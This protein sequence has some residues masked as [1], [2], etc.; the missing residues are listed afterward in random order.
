MSHELLYTS[1]E[2]GLKPGSYGFCTVMATEGLSKAL[3]DRLESLSGYEHPFAVTDKRSAQNPVNYSHLIVTVANQRLHLLSRIADA[4]AD[5]SGRSNKLAH[6][7][8]LEPAELTPAGPATTLATVDFCKTSFDGTPRELPEGVRPPAESRPASECVAWNAVC[9]DAGWAGVLAEQTLQNPSRPITL[10]FPPGCDVL[11]LVVEAMSLLPADQRWRTTF[12]TYFTKLPAGVDCQWRF[13][14]DGTPTADQARRNLQSPPIDLSSPGALTSSGPLVE[15]ARTGVMP[16]AGVNRPTA[17]SGGPTVSPKVTTASRLPVASTS[18]AARPIASLSAPP[19]PGSAD[20]PFAKEGMSPSTLWLLIGGGIVAVLGLGIGIGA[21]MM[22]SAPPPLP[23]VAKPDEHQEPEVEK[24]NFDIVKNSSK[25]TTDTKPVQA[26][27]VATNSTTKPDAQTT[28]TPDKLKF[29]FKQSIEDIAA[30]GNVLSLPKREQ[31]LQP[32]VGEQELCK[33]FLNDLDDLKL[34]LITTEALEDGQPKQFLVADANTPQEVRTWTVFSRAK[35]STLQVLEE[36]AIGKFTLRDQTLIFEWLQAPNWTS[37][38]GL[39]YCKLLAQVGSEQVECSL[40]RATTKP[41]E[42]LDLSR[43]KLSV[44][45]EIY[46]DSLSSMRYVRYDLEL[47]LDDWSE[48]KTGVRASDNVVQQFTL[49]AI[50]GT[51]DTRVQLELQ[52][53]PPGKTDAAFAY[54]S[55]V[56]PT[57]IR[58]M[59]G[60]WVY[61]TKRNDEV[62]EQSREGFALNDFERYRKKAADEKRKAMV[63]Q[64][65]ARRPISGL[66]SQIKLKEA[67]LSALQGSGKDKVIESVRNELQDLRGRLGIQKGLVAT[68]QEAIDHGDDVL[69]W[70]TNM[71]KRFEEIQQKLE[72]RFT[73]YLEFLSQSKVEQIVLVETNP[74][75]KSRT[76]AAEKNKD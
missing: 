72:V 24:P 36:V 70:T 50:D 34:K 63:E 76:V 20:N 69:N 7:V 32:L 22:G 42:H 58:P 66:E 44:P 71:K 55:L 51:G 74:P 48:A 53:T 68:W 54:R 56:F 9:H 40:V 15:A 28:V 45:V 21:S 57:V 17:A 30:K 52:F 11:S 18:A 10:I 67:E 29:T 5:Y 64:V 41:A 38:F 27:Q 43:P 35:N 8:A 62:D 49:P 2:R 60:K 73:V 59:D 23:A 13:V 16:A 1:A 4:G 75:P 31:G 47:K 46:A 37:P 25:S 19:R 33:V 12:S 39:L 26:H 65:N 61:F 14:L 3:Q 6:H